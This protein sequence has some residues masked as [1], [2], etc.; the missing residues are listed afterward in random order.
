MRSRC[1]WGAHGEGECEP[2]RWLA[3]DPCRVWVWHET[4]CP[5]FAQ[6]EKHLGFV[7][8]L[9][10]LSIWERMHQH[11]TH[12]LWLARGCLKHVW[13]WHLVAWLVG[14]VCGTPP[15][16]HVLQRLLV[17]APPGTQLY[18][19]VLSYER[20]EDTH[21]ATVP[22]FQ[23][24]CWVSC[25]GFASCHASRGRFFPCSYWPCADFWYLT[26]SCWNKETFLLRILS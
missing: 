26:A 7:Q 25:C 19:L 10:T 6:Q 2:G 22:T 3:C 14:G 4:K 11:G 13:G 15:V 1:W 18:L 20:E 5:V 17:V 16:T 24:A 9:W 21:G 23:L 8:S 12:K